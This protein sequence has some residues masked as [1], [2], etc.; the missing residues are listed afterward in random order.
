[1]LIVL[2]PYLLLLYMKG[3]E[4]IAISCAKQFS[5]SHALHACTAPST[6]LAS[7]P[8]VRIVLRSLRLRRTS[9]TSKHFRENLTLS[10]KLMESFQQEVL[11]HLRAF[12]GGAQ[13]KGHPCCNALTSAWEDKH[14]R[15][16]SSG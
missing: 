8:V 5:W 4:I 16:S 13:F 6:M 14:F 1:M 7:G 10:P 15:V 9:A 12:G 11:S 2:R 3:Y